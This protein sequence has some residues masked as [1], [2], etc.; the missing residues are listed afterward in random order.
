MSLPLLWGFFGVHMNVWL[1]AMLR[2]QIV[3]I[4]MTVVSCQPKCRFPVLGL[5]NASLIRS[6]L[7]LLA[8]N[9]IR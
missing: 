7:P 9:P 8:P 5:R 3:V 2:L 4:V 6:G 1:D